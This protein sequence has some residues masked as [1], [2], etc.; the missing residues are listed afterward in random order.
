MNHLD[1]ISAAC[2][3]LVDPDLNGPF[4]HR[5]TA[6]QAAP[7]EWVT[8]WSDETPPGPHCQLIIAHS[9]AVSAI[10]HWESEGPI[11]GFHADSAATSLPIAENELH[12]RQQVI[13]VGYP[14]VIDH[15]AFSIHRGSLTPERY[16]PYLCP[17]IIRGHVALFSAEQAWLAGAGYHGMVGS[18]VVN[19]EGAVLGM[20]LDDQPAEPHVP[21]LSPFLRVTQ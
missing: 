15:P 7:G 1:A 16:H 11:A 5:A 4:R 13:C 10:S 12:K 19:H 9:G 21:P 8:V 3:V 14:S 6:W 18:P 20:L 17:W 2:G